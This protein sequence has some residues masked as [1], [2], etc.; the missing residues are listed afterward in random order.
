MR[1]R[2]IDTVMPFSKRV[3]SKHFAEM[4]H[5]ANTDDAS[6]DRIMELLKHSDLDNAVFEDGHLLIS[7]QGSRFLGEVIGIDT[8]SAL[9][10]THGLT[11]CAVSLSLNDIAESLKMTRMLGDG[12]LFSRLGDNSILQRQGNNTSL[13]LRNTGFS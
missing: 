13:L 2:D 12:W 9:T 1:V 7:G 5:D 4:R 6:E 11:E 8:A 3:L 10:I